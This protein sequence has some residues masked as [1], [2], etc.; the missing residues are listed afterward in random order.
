[1][2]GSSAANLD[3]IFAQRLKTELV[4]KGS[5]AVNLAG[6]HIEGFSDFDDGLARQKAF[7]F[8]YLLQDR[9]QVFAC[10]NWRIQLVFD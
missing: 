7:F 6:R 2:A 4:I 1:M 3:V 5:H 9:D 10:R 8:L